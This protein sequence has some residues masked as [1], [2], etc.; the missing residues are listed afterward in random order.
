MNLPSS[1]DFINIHTH[2]AEPVAGI[3]SVDTLM[4]HEGINPGQKPG[5]AYSFGIHPWY[6]TSENHDYLLGQ[7]EKMASSGNIIAVGEAGFDKIKGP[8]IGL[9]RKTFE[10]QVSIADNY[11]KPVVIH[12]VR[13][14]DEL[15][16]EH[17]K[18]KP[19][20]PWLVHGFRGKADLALQLISRGMYLSFWFS[21][22]IRPE[23]TQLIKRLPGNRIFL[24]TDG[25]DID[26]RVIYNK[27][28][29]DLEIT[30][31]ELKNLI[32]NNF[33]NLFKE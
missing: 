7:V 30:V 33:K 10:E 8:V 4:A 14:W 3:F 17:K 11:R 13:Y 26:I 22:I 31:D 1:G 6:L 16:Q 20:T 29:A 21:F 9:Q 19:A 2:G 5:I 25:A 24:E 23:S 28:S 27:V 18:L 32:L 12:C 15:L